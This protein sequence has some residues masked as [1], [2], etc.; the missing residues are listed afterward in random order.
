MRVDFIC[1]ETGVA[2]RRIFSKLKHELESS[3]AFGTVD[4]RLPALV[5]HLRAE[6]PEDG[7]EVCDR[8]VALRGAHHVAVHLPAS[9]RARRLALADRARRRQHLVPRRGF[10]QTM[11]FENVFTVEEKLRVADVRQGIERARLIRMTAESD[12]RRHEIF[13]RPFYSTLLV[14][15]HEVCQRI[16]CRKL[17]KPRIVEHDEIIRARARVQINQL[18]LEK[19]GVRKLCD[20]D[21]NARLRFVIARSI[22]ER[23]TFDTGDDRERQLL[24]VTAAAATTT[25]TLASGKRRANER[26]RDENGDARPETDCS[27]Y[28]AWPRLAQSLLG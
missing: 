4:C 9:G 25:S 20:V 15:R 21:M 18:F 14:E 22:F 6:G 17:R 27:G 16:L 1:I 24:S 7:H 13:I 28:H 3:N 11:L 23:V 10:F 12:G 5:K 2:G 26:E 8:R 19:I